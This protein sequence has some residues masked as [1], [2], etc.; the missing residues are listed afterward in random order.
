MRT[1]QPKKNKASSG[2][3]TPA[4][5]VVVHLA[6]QA[7]TTSSKLPPC[8]FFSK[9]KRIN[10]WRH[11]QEV[12][13][14]EIN[15][16]QVCVWKK[17]CCRGEREGE[18]RRGEDNLHRFIRQ[19]FRGNCARCYCNR[20]CTKTHQFIVKPHSGVSRKKRCWLQ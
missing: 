15:Q 5:F 11:T 6:E 10:S 19:F 7:E 2:C 1:N 12:L 4:R 3:E 8:Y 16:E 9:K 13:Q 17:R 14:V 20:F 18:R